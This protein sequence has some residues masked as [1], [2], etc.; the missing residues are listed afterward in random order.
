MYNCTTVK[1]DDNKKLSYFIYPKFQLVV[2]HT[3]GLFEISKTSYTDIFRA[4][5]YHNRTIMEQQP[6]LWNNSARNWINYT[7][8]AGKKSYLQHILTQIDS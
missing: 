4:K 1:Y 8:R 7:R 6:S 5:C 3:V 2:W